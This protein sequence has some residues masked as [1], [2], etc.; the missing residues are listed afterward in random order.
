MDRL[1]LLE[2]STETKAT[3]SN[4][5][6][7]S[8]SPSLPERSTEPKATY[9]SL[10]KL[11]KSTFLLERSTDSKAIYSSSPKLGKST[12]MLERFA[13][14]KATYPNF[15][16]S[17]KFPSLLEPSAESK[18]TNSTYP[19]VKESPS[20]SFSLLSPQYTSV[21]Q[22]S[23]NYSFNQDTFSNVD[24]SQ[25][26]SPNSQNADAD[27]YSD[28]LVFKGMFLHLHFILLTK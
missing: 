27:L 14:T 17:C 3:N 7:S 12:S 11:E 9:S 26:F 28:N 24:H 2:R 20:N 23:K 19:N 1:L 15:L 8:D 13:E 16:N 25:S 4:F 22:I 21:D 6:N 18:A 5:L 10:P